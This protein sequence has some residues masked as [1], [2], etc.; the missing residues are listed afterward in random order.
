MKDSKGDII[1]P[2][3]FIDRAKRI[4]LYSEITKKVI[5]KSFEFFEGK[6]IEFS[7]NLSISDILEKEVVDFLIQKIYEYDIGYFLTIE[8]TESEGIDN[9]EEVIS[10]IKIVK[11]LGVKIAIDDFGTGYSNFSY[12]V[13]LQ[14][15]FIKIDGSIIQDINK[16]KTAKAVIEAIVFF[17]KKVGMK[18]VA[19]FVSSKDI[20]KACKE[21]E[22]DYFQGYLFDEPKN[23]DSLKE[24]INNKK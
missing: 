18:T 3:F 14:A 1:S 20:F 24:F 23:I 22:I 13:K 10:F 2:Y 19:E 6:S 21:L 17:S 7:I 5:Q 16:S 15:D 12:L 4:N 11:N 8:I 9:F